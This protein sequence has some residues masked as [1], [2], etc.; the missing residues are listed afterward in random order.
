MT[1]FYLAAAL[2]LAITMA[3]GLL[4]LFRGPTPA[5]RI[6]AGQLFGTTATALLFLLAE[7]QA[8]PALQDVGFVFALLAAVTSIAFAQR[9]WPQAGPEERP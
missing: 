3:A 6:L 5:D 9:L 2:V 7:A 4:R 8:M 1:V